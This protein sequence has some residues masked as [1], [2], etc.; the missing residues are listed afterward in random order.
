[1][2]E[3]ELA[4]LVFLIFD[5]HFNR[6]TYLQVRIVTELAGGDDTVALVA[7]VNYNFALTD[8]DDCTV[9]HFVFVYTTEGVVV[10]L[11][12]FFVALRNLSCAVF[13]CVPVKVRKR[14]NVL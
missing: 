9:N 5:V 10:S 11:F 1:M 14:C 7:D 3:H 8:S 13:E 12:L 2:R 4:T 6:V